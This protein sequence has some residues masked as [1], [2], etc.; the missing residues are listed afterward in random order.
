MSMSSDE[1]SQTNQRIMT[2]GLTYNQATLRALVEAASETWAIVAADGTFLEVDPVGAAGAEL[3]ASGDI[4]GHSLFEFI[5]PEDEA[6]AGQVRDLLRQGK[7]GRFECVMIGG[8]ERRRKFEYRLVPLP[9]PPGEERRTAL[10]VRDLTPLQ[11]IER[12]RELLA[13]IVDSSTDAVIAMDRDAI[14]TAWNRGAHELYGLSAGKVVG[15]PVEAYLSNQSAAE[16]RRIV[17][18]VI[19]SGGL[20]QYEARRIRKDGSIIDIWAAAFCIFD[21]TGRVAG[22]SIA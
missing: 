1:Q 4:R 6:V 3:D 16:V 7:A 10:F 17:G 19:K 15:R 13:C 21:A 11:T 2:T 8:K 9:T 12:N 18:E 5:A 14:I 20:Q 22:V